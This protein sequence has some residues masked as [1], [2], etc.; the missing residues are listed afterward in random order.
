MQVQ[1]LQELI[2]DMIISKLTA[3]L[4]DKL[5][6]LLL[7]IERAQKINASFYLFKKFMKIRGKSRTLTFQ[8]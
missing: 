6:S 3:Y 8:N 2:L 5:L 1:K 4:F 7:S